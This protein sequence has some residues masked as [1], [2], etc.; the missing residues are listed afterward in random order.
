MPGDLQEQPVARC[1]RSSASS[2]LTEVVSL[3]SFLER[4]C[5]MLVCRLGISLVMHSAAQVAPPR[6]LSLRGGG[7]P[8]ECEITGHR[9]IGALK[10]PRVF[11]LGAGEG[12]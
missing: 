5:R 3:L 10:Q 11:P 8:A 9:D 6:W 2:G 12:S 7:Q 4:T 1:S